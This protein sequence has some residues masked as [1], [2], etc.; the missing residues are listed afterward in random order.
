[1]HNTFK[2]LLVECFH[3]TSNFAFNDEPTCFDTMKHLS[4]NY[5][6]FVRGVFDGCVTSAGILER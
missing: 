2:H 5:A 6:R 1:M 3:L 4:N